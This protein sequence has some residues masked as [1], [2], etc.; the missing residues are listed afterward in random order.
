M[1]SKILKMK[2]ELKNTYQKIRTR[3]LKMMSRSKITGNFFRTTM[4]LDLKHLNLNLKTRLIH[5]HIEDITCFSS[6]HMCFLKMMNIITFKL[7]CRT[8]VI[9]LISLKI[10]RNHSK[11]SFEN[12]S[13]S[14]KSAVDK[15]FNR[16]LDCWYGDLDPD[17]IRK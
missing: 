1:Y 9:S 4:L 8:S 3:K 14:M 7:L 12:E 6:K 13:C 5:I 15:T 16:D 10:S 2:H 11:T 17:K